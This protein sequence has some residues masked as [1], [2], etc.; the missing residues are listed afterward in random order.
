MTTN[1]AAPGRSQEEC[2]DAFASRDFAPSRVPLITPFIISFCPDT[3]RPLDAPRELCVRFFHAL[4]AETI[5]E[6]LHGPNKWAL[7]PRNFILA[8]SR[9]NLIRAAAEGRVLLMTS[10]RERIRSAVQADFNAAANGENASKA[11]GKDKWKKSHG[12]R[13]REIGGFL[14]NVKGMGL[15]RLTLAVRGLKLTL[16]TE[17][18]EEKE[19]EEETDDEAHDSVFLRGSPED[20]RAHEHIHH[21]L[22]WGRVYDH[23]LRRALYYA[24]YGND[25]FSPR[26]RV[27]ERALRAAGQ[28]APRTQSDIPLRISSF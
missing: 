5:T 28:T 19:T 7:D 18:L 23:D 6:M 24:A 11:K 21:A 26:E 10:E 17:H 2:A 8:H 15:Y 12:V 22:G 1:D 9:E 27:Q 16:L 3:L 25:N 13:F 4:D 14:C 20:M